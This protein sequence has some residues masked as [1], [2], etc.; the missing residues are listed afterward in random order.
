MRPKILRHCSN[1]TLS[2]TTG[3]V[4]QVRSNN[5]AIQLTAAINPDNSGGRVLDM[6]GG[7]LGIASPKFLEFA[8]GR[9]VDGLA[10]ALMEGLQ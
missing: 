9:S 3:I 7:V 5:G 8:V 10:T 1:T 4:S 2:A 6:S